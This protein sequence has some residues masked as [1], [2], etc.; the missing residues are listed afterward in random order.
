M[1]ATIPRRYVLAAL[2]GSL[3]LCALFVGTAAGASTDLTTLTIYNDSGQSLSNAPVTFGQ[4]FKPGDVAAGASLEAR[5]GTGAAVPL[6]IDKKSSYADG[7]LK[8]AVL[9]ARLDGVAAG[10]TQSLILANAASG[11]AGTPVSLSA[12]LATSFDAV[13]NLNIS[14][15]VYSASAR[16]LLG[17][18][19]QAWLQGP[20][21]SEWLVRG[22][23]R[24][25]GGQAHPHLEAL[26]AVRAYAGNPI[27]RVRVDVTI[28]NGKTFATGVGTFTYDASIVV[29]GSTVFTRPALAHHQ[30]S[31]WRKVFWWGGDPGVT[32]AHEASYL[33]ATNAVPN[34]D[35]TIVISASVLNS[36]LSQWNSAPNGPLQE[37]HADKYMPQTGGRPEIGP[38]PRWDARHIISQDPRARPAVLGSGD[39][40]GS[41]PIHY[42]DENTGYLPTIDAYPNIWTDNLPGNFGERDSAAGFTPDW[43]HQPSFGYYA[44]LITGDYYYLEEVQYWA[45]WNMISR[46]PED[47]NRDGT[48][49]LLDG[50]QVRALG[51]NLR[52]LMQAAW[53][54]PDDHPMKAYFES[55]LDSNFNHL[56]Q[57]YLTENR[58][59]LG[60]VASYSDVFKVAAW[61]DDFVTHA[62]GWAH[63]VGYAKATSLMRGWKGRF[64]VERL[65]DGTGNLGCWSVSAPYRTVVLVSS[66]RVQLTTAR[67]IF[68]STVRDI[69]NA[70]TATNIL[71]A[72]CGT[73][74]Q[75][76]AFGYSPGEIFGDYPDD[77]ESYVANMQSAIAVSVDAGVAGAS[78]A[79]ARFAQNTNELDYV[80]NPQF[81]IVPV[82]SQ[83]PPPPSAPTVSFSAN[84]MT[85]QPGG[86]SDLVW[87]STN[88]TSCTA[89]GAWSGSKATSGS[90]STG[91]LNTT[92]TYTLSC[93]GS[94]GGSAPRSV[95]VTVSSSAPPAP[96]VSLAVDP[97][98]V[99]VNGSSTLTWSSTNATSCTASGGWSG[100]KETSGSESTG[101]LSSTTSYTLSCTG[102]G[103]SSA[104]QTVTV[105]VNGGGGGTN[106]PPED[107]GGGGA[108]EWWLLAGLLW[109]LQRR[110][111]SLPH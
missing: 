40:G 102:A 101:A 31:R 105:T 92:S 12:L 26:F 109:S 27:N 52:T 106:P 88:A 16:T 97:T 6:Q 21:V 64:V 66:T 39:L 30:H 35:P 111:P 85:V 37:G 63:N 70:T 49:G 82:A 50:D 107:S 100:T 53:I 56:T 94:G 69:W 98:S 79:W 75:F 3:T 46:S 99:A 58:A 84:P 55:K 110:R 44:Y 65:G 62:I 51:W 43:S 45:N 20:L 59:P 38:L 103:G 91:A 78:A 28:E 54:T 23:L 87:S 29:G 34:Y 9:T 42:R 22:P 13:V 24:T 47:W 57:L 89:S 73:P 61:M 32:V 90:Q 67:E 4:V 93:T 48:K 83:G 7:S 33:R 86:S 19:P 11:A 60:Y 1:H 17:A 18:Q 10:A 76:Q 36:A 5:L 74:Q 2:R 104:P 81:A 68:E 80:S 25:A 77:P 72:G 14:G 41:W 71:A 108:L 8:F 96:T 15:T 95:T